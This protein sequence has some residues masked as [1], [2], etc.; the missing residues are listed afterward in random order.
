MRQVCWDPFHSV[1]LRFFL[2][3]VKFLLGH[4]VW[5][6]ANFQNFLSLDKKKRRKYQTGNGSNSYI[7]LFFIHQYMV[8]QV[9]IY[10]LVCGHIFLLIL[11]ISLD[12]ILAKSVPRAHFPHSFSFG[13][14]THF[15]QSLIQCW[16]PLL[17][18]F[19][20]TQTSTIFEILLYKWLKCL[21]K[22]NQNILTFI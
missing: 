7:F 2:I 10:L 19:Y 3:W 12:D 6:K 20:H 18:I 17:Q 14:L 15:S 21:C 1:C 9:L 5:S 13:N 4:T 11:P 16:K 22:I 8:H